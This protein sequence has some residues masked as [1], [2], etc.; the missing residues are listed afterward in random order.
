M[1]R[2]ALITTILAGTMTAQ[3]ADYQYLTIEKNDGTATS[4]TA[5]GLTLNY[6]NGTLTA[7][8]G[9]EQA[10]IALTDLKRMYFTNTQSTTAIESV[11]AS[12]DDWN[13]AATEIYD[14]SGRRLP[15]GRKPACG[16]YIFKKGSTTTK[17]YVK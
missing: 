16:L 9:T 15:Q 8:N 7:T 5:I 10:T 3:A 14:L 2:H 12:A 13:D 17:K 11:E 1:K 4:L 6:S